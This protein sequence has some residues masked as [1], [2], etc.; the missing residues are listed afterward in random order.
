MFLW[1]EENLGIDG[2]FYEGVFCV[3]GI[4]FKYGIDVR[5]EVVFL[6]VFFYDYY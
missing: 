1:E 2:V 3:L 5:V 6:E 4:F